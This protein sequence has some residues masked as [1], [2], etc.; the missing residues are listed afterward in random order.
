MHPC[1]E[2]IGGRIFAS[3]ACL[4]RCV[5]NHHETESNEGKG[6]IRACEQDC[7]NRFMSL[8]PVDGSLIDGNGDTPDYFV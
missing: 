2:A 3:L 1:L 7:N 8:M 5:Y 6:F 4:L